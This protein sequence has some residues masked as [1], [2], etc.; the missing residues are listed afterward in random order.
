MR[1][2]TLL[3]SL[4]LLGC[5]G[6]PKS[7]DEVK[8]LTKSAPPA[9]GIEVSFGRDVL[10][11]LS[12][13]CLACHGPETPAGNY[14]VNSFCNVIA[15]GADSVANVLGGSPDRSLLYTYMAQGHPPA[16]PPDS[17]TLRIVRQWIEQGASDN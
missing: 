15:N 5:G 16:A 11:L 13:Q 12:A 2:L 6:K 10:P 8:P 17:T 1:W 9:A 3:L 4:S 14:A 7:A